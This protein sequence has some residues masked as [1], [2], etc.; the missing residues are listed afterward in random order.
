MKANNPH[1]YRIRTWSWGQEVTV[2]LDVLKSP[3]WIKCRGL[4]RDPC[5]VAGCKRF[6]DRGDWYVRHPFLGVVCRHCAATFG[7]FLPDETVHSLRQL[8]TEDLPTQPLSPPCELPCPENVH[9]GELD[10]PFS[11]C[12]MK[13]PR[14]VQG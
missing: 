1:K 4:L 2:Y 9:Q 8:L 5:D 10:C 6:I 12:P 14:G 13:S 3:R 11:S 7:A